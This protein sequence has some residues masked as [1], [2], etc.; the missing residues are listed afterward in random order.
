MNE[1]LQAERTLDLAPD[2]A[3][4]KSD[5]SE[6]VDASNSNNVTATQPNGLLF[7]AALR[8]KA[9]GSRSIV[10]DAIFATVDGDD[11][12]AGKSFLDIRHRSKREDRRKP[13]YSTTITNRSTEQIRIDR[14]G[15]YM[16]KGRAL[17]LHSITGG[18]FS[19]QQ[20]QE[21]YE[22]GN[23]WLEPGQVVTD[24]NNHSQVGVFWAYFGTTASGK[25]FVTGAA[26]NG[27]RW[28]Q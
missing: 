24:P 7:A 25:Q 26:W 13:Y 1:Q 15:T 8:A 23:E 11:L 21:W 10:E 18:V 6:T 4:D 5:R 28:W 9:N 17:V 3:I 12:K 19:G 14:F 22:L 27:K 16:K 2:L 20:F